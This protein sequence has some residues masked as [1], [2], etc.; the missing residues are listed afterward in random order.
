MHIA[1]TY[2]DH[3]DAKSPLQLAQ[4]VMYQ[5][6]TDLWHTLSDSEQFTWQSLARRFHMSG[7]S[8]YMSKC[9]A[10]NPGIYLPLAGGTMKGNVDMDSNKIENLPAPGASAEPSR[11]VDLDTHLALLTGVHGLK[12]KLT[13]E[14]YRNAPQS[15]PTVTNT[16]ILYDTVVE[17]TGNYWNSVNYTYQPLIPGDYLFACGTQLSNLVTGKQLYVLIYKTALL[18]SF[19][20]RQYVGATGSPVVQGARRITLNGSTD[21]VYVAIYHNYG[22]NRSLTTGSARTWLQAYLIPQT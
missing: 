18:Y 6:C 11:K 8:L 15:I 3:P 20:G 12:G 13:F 21:Y 1:E 10:P 5:Q 9:L 22:S 16:R 4:R 17:D 2:P 19:V 14:V 7:Y